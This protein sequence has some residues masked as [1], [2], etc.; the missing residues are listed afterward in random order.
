METRIPVVSLFL[1][2]GTLI[3]SACA[4]TQGERINPVEQAS[5]RGTVKIDVMAFDPDRAESISPY[6]QLLT[7]TDTQILDQFLDACSAH[8]F[9]QAGPRFSVK[10]IN[11]S[12]ASW[13]SISR[14]R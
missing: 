1:A 7:I 12:M 8:S 10:A 9:L 13:V 6:V 3:M 2:L 11:P 4:L 14:S 5:L